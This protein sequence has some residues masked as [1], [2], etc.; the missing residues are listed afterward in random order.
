MKPPMKRRLGFAL[1]LGRGV[2][3]LLVERGDHLRHRGGLVHPHPEI[4]DETG[5]A[6]RFFEVVAAKNQEIRRRLAAHRADDLERD[7]ERI[8]RA[9]QHDLLADVP[10]EALHGAKARPG[11]PCAGV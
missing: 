4:I 5:P 1:R 6:G 8:E 2:G 11:M 9:A 10:V 7:V 3:E